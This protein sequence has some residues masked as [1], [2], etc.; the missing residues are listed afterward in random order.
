MSTRDG[1]RP[2]SPVPEEDSCPV[3]KR[4]KKDQV[5]SQNDFAIAQQVMEIC[6]KRGVMGRV[7]SAEETSKIMLC[8]RAIKESATDK[9]DI[10][11][12]ELVGVCRFINISAQNGVIHPS[13]F[14][15]VGALYARIHSFVVENNK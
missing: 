3:D 1:K 11:M 7:A 13:E 14:Q 10:E 8:Y 9:C 12:S 6:I 5:L 2:L 4:A 15:V